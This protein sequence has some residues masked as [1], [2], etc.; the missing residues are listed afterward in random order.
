MNFF[1]YQFRP[2]QP[3]EELSRE[4]KNRIKKELNQINKELLR[5]ERGVNHCSFLFSG[6]FI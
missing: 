3:L 5:K 1:S 4:G 6:N 2:K